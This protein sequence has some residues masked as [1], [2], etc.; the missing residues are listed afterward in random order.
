METVLYLQ[1]RDLKDY[2][3]EEKR[4]NWKQKNAC[5]GSVIR[6]LNSSWI[7]PKL[8]ETKVCK[9]VVR[10]FC[11][12][13][14]RIILSKLLNPSWCLCSETWRNFISN[15]RNFEIIY[16]CVCVMR[17]LY[18]PHHIMR[19]LYKPHH[20]MKQLYKPHHVNE[21]AVQS[22]RFIIVCYFNT[23]SLHY[24]CIILSGLCCFVLKWI[25]SPMMMYCK[26]LLSSVSPVRYC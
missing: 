10:Y 19:L 13:C 7:A 23:I 26:A 11:T 5:I 17:Q 9:N 6:L 16:P 12:F 8:A 14:F 22:T 25:Q 15:I 2:S 1:E 21:T 4:E 18:K 24:D 20:I 3:A